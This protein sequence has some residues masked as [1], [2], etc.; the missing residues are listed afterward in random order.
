MTAPQN[1]EAVKPP[2]TATPTPV[3]PDTKPPVVVN[4]PSPSV[5]FAD[6]VAAFGQ[7]L[8]SVPEKIV[9]ALR[10]STPATDTTPATQPATT[11][12]APAAV[13]A[14]APKTGRSRFHAWWFGNNG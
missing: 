6:A 14:T 7:Q 1:P 2:E 8:A 13:S 11:A 12:P 5:N 9:D 4:A 3:V 10:E